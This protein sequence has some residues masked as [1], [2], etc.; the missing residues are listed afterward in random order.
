MEAQDWRKI[1]NT[2]KCEYRGTYRIS[3]IYSKIKNNICGLMT[4]R[5]KL[6]YINGKEVNGDTW[7]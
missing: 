1:K 2:K 3:K 4:Y 6:Y 5:S 7:L